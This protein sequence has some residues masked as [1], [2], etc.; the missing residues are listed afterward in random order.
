MAQDVINVL[1]QR[2]Q[3]LQNFLLFDG[4]EFKGPIYSL[5]PYFPETTMMPVSNST[6]NG[7]PMTGY[8]STGSHTGMGMDTSMDMG[9]A[10]LE[11]NGTKS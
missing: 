10:T 3:P 4:E 9:P 5:Y 2:E 1:G 6:P 11:T 8:M 7:T